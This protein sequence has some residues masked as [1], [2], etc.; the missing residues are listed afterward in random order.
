MTAGGTTRL[1]EDV[2]IHGDYWRVSGL[3][4]DGAIKAW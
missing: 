4:Q 1:R 2:R 3:P